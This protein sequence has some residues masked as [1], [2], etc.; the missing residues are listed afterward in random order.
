MNPNLKCLELNPSARI[1]LALTIIRRADFLA[2]EA[3]LLD[4]IELFVQYFHVFIEILV[5]FD[6]LPKCEIKMTVNRGVECVPFFHFLSLT[7]FK[8]A[9]RQNLLF[10]ETNLLLR[11]EK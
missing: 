9:F 5:C 4:L 7:L 6:F 8:K 1:K 11:C 3:D 2:S 10:N